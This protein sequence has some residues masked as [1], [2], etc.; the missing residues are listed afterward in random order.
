MPRARRAR[1]DSDVRSVNSVYKVPLLRPAEYDQAL[2]A[3]AVKRMRI[4]LTVAM[5]SSLDASS[6]DA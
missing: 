4:V 5:A 3:T 6:L 1:Q 2:P